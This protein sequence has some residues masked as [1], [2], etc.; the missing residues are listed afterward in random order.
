MLESLGLLGLFLGSLLAST[1]IP[2]PSDALLVANIA[3]GSNMWLCIFL[4]TLG[5]TLGGMTS[6]LLGW[7]GKWA[8][9]EK[10]F[11]I[12]YEKILAFQEK[13]NRYKAFIAFFAWLPFVGDLIA[14]TLG[15]MKITPW[16][17]CLYMGVGRLVRFLVVGLAGEGILGL[18]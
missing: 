9:I 7:F 5:N 2:F 1:I 8:W 18:I 13:V 11:K 12:S 10:Y 16:K 15:F 6:Y 17:S 4:A 14:I 3:M